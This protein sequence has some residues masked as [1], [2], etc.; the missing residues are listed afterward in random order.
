MNQDHWLLKAG[1]VG[2]LVEKDRLLNQKLKSHCVQP[3][4]LENVNP[5]GCCLLESQGIHKCSNVIRN[6]LKSATIIDQS[7]QNEVCGKE[8]RRVC[9]EQTSAEFEPFEWGVIEERQVMFKS[10]VNE[11]VK[12]KFLGK[13]VNKMLNIRS[14]VI[15]LKSKLLME[16]KMHFA[17]T[18]CMY[19]IRQLA[20][21]RRNHLLVIM[22]FKQRVNFAKCIRDINTGSYY[23]KHVTL[24]IEISPVVMIQQQ[25]RLRRVNMV[26]QQAGLKI[27]LNQEILDR[28]AQCNRKALVIR[29]IENRF[30][31]ATVCAEVRS[32]V[33]LIKA[34]STT[35][36]YNNVVKELEQRI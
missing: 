13:T 31:K 28:Q 29:E 25:M 22:E 12:S 36:N 30:A 9:R 26:I 4:V 1:S 18:K 24:P 10:L 34:R 20:L 33:K 11:A 35:V 27:K 17:K 14:K 21:T 16:L 23:L 2:K 3:V 19:E 8:T 7:N 5:T 6:E 32:K 15:G